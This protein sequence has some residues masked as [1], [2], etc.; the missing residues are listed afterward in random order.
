MKGSES[1]LKWANNI[2][3]KWT[4]QINNELS[5]VSQRSDL[6]SLPGWLEI[7]TDLH[8]K[9]AEKINTMPSAS[10]VIDRKMIDFGAGMMKHALQIYQNEAK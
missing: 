8:G 6:D 4:H 1:Q 3:A 2:Q 10:V 9:Y 5:S 7:V